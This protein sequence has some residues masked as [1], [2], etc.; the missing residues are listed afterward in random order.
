[1]PEKTEIKTLD[2]PNPVVYKREKVDSFNTARYS[3]LDELIRDDSQELPDAVTREEIFDI[4]RGVHDPEYP[5]SLEQL[6][7][8]ELN[9]IFLYD[10]NVI[11]IVFRPTIP[12]CSQVT[13]IGL[14]LR[15]KLCRCLPRKYKVDIELAEGS[16]NSE[17]SVNKQLNDKERVAAAL[18]NAALQNVVDEGVSDTDFWRSLVLHR[19]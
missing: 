4:I 9:N 7:V 12:H 5:Y 11:R 19:W 8:V 16:H 1:M 6:R 17:V 13:L 10:K 2:N 18:E 3:Y 15:E 14:M